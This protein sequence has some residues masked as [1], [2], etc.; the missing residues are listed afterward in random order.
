MK[1]VIV[2]ASW[3]ADRFIFNHIESLRFQTSQDFV[4]GLYLD[5]MDPMYYVRVFHEVKD[6]E[7][8]IVMGSEEKGCTMNSQHKVINDLAGEDDV[9]I[10]LD[11][12]DAFNI[13]TV[14]EEVMNEYLSDSNLLLT[15]GNLVPFPFD[16]RCPTAQPYPRACV[17]NRDFRLASKYG[18][19]FNHLRTM[20]YSLWRAI[21]DSYRAWEDGSLF[22]VAGDAAEMICGLEMAGPDRYKYIDRPYVRYT[23]NNGLSDWRRDPRLINRTHA[24][25][26]SLPKL[27]LL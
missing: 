13:P 22:T 15:Y 19:Q 5:D 14:V 11:G 26:E 1:A 7:N 6:F 8:I 23:T 20:R 16:K 12:D 25:I 27:E 9:L 17:D 4:A 18:H 24:R 21:P 10:W 2:S 3:R